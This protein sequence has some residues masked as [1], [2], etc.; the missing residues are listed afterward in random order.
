MRSSHRRLALSV[1]CIARLP[2]RVLPSAK[3]RGGRCT[4][5]TT[6]ATNRYAQPVFSTTHNDTLA[7]RTD[8]TLHA[9]KLHRAP[10]PHPPES[11][12][13]LMRNARRRSS[14]ASQSSGTHSALVE[15]RRA[16]SRCVLYA[17]RRRRPVPQVR[18]RRVLT[19]I[20]G[21]ES[22]RAGSCPHLE[23]RDFIP[24]QITRRSPCI[25]PGIQ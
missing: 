4:L 1:R 10:T 25:V 14:C 3:A 17:I 12:P 13:S 24:A 2:A 9:R 15:M 8:G 11:P 19:R 6:G 7:P 5:R 22:Q 23:V 16:H 18:E 20:V 21:P